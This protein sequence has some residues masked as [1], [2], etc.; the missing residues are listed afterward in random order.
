MIVAGVGFDM[1]CGVVIWCVLRAAYAL[2]WTPL[3]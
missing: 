3:V 1:A 2:G